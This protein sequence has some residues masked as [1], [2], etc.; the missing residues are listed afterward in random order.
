MIVLQYLAGIA[1]V[2][3]VAALAWKASRDAE[4]LNSPHD[5]VQLMAEREAAE[6]DA[7][8]AADSMRDKLGECGGADTACIARHGRRVM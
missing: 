7:R 2:I 5:P 8:K 3:A 4:H 6:A 1:C